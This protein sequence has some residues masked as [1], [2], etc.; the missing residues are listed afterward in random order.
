MFRKPGRARQAIG[1]LASSKELMDAAQAGQEMPTEPVQYF[2]GG[3]GVNS[4]YSELGLYGGV[5]P[6]FEMV[7]EGDDAKIQ[8]IGG[9]EGSL[10][11]LYG[12]RDPS[13]VRSESG[14][15][16][17]EL[18]ARIAAGG[19]DSTTENIANALIPTID[20]IGKR[21]E[22][23][24]ATDLAVAQ[25]KDKKEQE[26]Q[27]RLE[28]AQAAQRQVN[29]KFSDEL[30]LIGASVDPQTGY[31]K[32]GKASEEGV[33]PAFQDI[34]ALQEYL[35]E[36]D[37]KQALARLQEGLDE[38]GG[39]AGERLYKAS[40]DETVPLQDFL[41]KS[42]TVNRPEKLTSYSEKQSYLETIKGPIQRKGGDIIFKG[43]DNSDFNNVRI[44]DF[45]EG[46]ALTAFGAVDGEFNK[47]LAPNGTELMVQG[48][49]GTQI[50]PNAVF[51]V[52]GGG[53]LSADS[54]EE[55][56]IELNK[57]LLAR[58]K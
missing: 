38:K 31:I 34:K 23:N 14:F 43:N 10:A 1:I 12:M 35:I 47:F 39:T 18:G 53:V 3:G 58:T 8:P 27:D 33:Q 37:N 30:S 2:N 19:S 22:K 48:F 57:L 40:L 4:I 17:L 52:K 46:K 29:L 45:K 5:A 41:Q 42:V 32:F 25:L 11:R 44:L 15:D 54:A 13:R 55:V 9:L 56:R 36:T 20:K 28:K 16:L 49:D 7:G 6:G 51:Y 50:P 21:R 24:L 26:A